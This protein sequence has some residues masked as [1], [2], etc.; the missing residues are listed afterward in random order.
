[1]KKFLP[2]R[3]NSL[4]KALH[5]QSVM[6]QS[7]RTTTREAERLQSS[8]CCSYPTETS[9]Q[10][11]SLRIHKYQGRG[12]C[13]H[14]PPIV[15]TETLIILH[16]SQKPNSIIVLLY[17][18][19]HIKTLVLLPAGFYICFLFQRIPH[20]VIFCIAGSTCR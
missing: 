4:K 1:M 3:R 5:A 15:L 11:T 12:K 6:G 14:L 17:I 20:T 2:P 16:I 8:K 13:Y 7:A 9:S 10:L 18:S 19:I